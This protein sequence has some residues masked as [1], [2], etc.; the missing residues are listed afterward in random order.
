MYSDKPAPEYKA[1]NLFYMQ[2]L[3]DVTVK[4]QK[5]IVIGK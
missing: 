3:L 2:L 4:K 5:Q 1:T